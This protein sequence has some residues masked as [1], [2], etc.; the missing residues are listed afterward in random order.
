[1]LDC[2]TDEVKWERGCWRQINIDGQHGVGACPPR[3]APEHLVRLLRCERRWEQGLGGGARVCDAPRLPPWMGGCSHPDG[4]SAEL[5]S[6]WN[7]R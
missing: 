1:M 6:R 7:P 3:R 5:V 4:Q 2:E